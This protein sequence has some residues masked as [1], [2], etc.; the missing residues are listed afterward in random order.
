[1]TKDTAAEILRGHARPATPLAECLDKAREHTAGDAVRTA[2]IELAARVL[3][4]VP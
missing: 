4:L 1:M 2:R 3:G